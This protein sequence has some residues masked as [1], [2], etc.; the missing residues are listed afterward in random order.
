MPNARHERVSGTSGREC[1]GRECRGRE[2]GSNERREGRFLK[3]PSK[4]YPSRLTH[5]QYSPHDFLNNPR[6]ATALHS[7][8]PRRPG[9]PSPSLSLPSSSH[10]PSWSRSQQCRPCKQRPLPRGAVS[11]RQSSLKQEGLMVTRT[12]KNHGRSRLMARTDF[13]ENTIH[14]R[15]RRA[16]RLA[17]FLYQVC[18]ARPDII[19]LKLRFR[20]HMPI[21]HEV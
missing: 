15:S 9:T 21:A 18:G 13:L 17:A 12:S 7:T 2:E 19:T 11:P 4:T 5:I 16:M 3:N 10:Q 1:Q 8:W 14:E 20:G 6:P